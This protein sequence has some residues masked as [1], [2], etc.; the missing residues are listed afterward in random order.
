M[1]IILAD[2]ESRRTSRGSAV[3]A[4]LP[5][6]IDIPNA[7]TIDKYYQGRAEAL[8]IL[9]RIFSSKKTGEDILPSYLARFYIAVHKGLKVSW[10]LF[11]KFI[12]DIT[13]NQRD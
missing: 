6:S 11:V 7:I 10:K 8:A 9:C 12:V 1:R 3:P 4:A 5:E 13:P 2:G